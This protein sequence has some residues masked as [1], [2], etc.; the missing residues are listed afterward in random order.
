VS[1]E[2]PAAT[3]A[4]PEFVNQLKGALEVALVNDGLYADE[5][6]AMVDT[7]ER[8]YFLTP[9]VRMLYLLPQ[10]ETD[11]IIP[12]TISPVP[13]AVKR[14]M[15]IRLELMTPAHEKLLATWLTE[16]SQ[17][18]TAGAAREKFRSLGRFAEPHLSR[19]WTQSKVDAERNAASGLMKEI[20]SQ[21]KWTSTAVE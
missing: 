18:P 16:L 1:A 11:K 10:A 3:L 17:A 13:K 8:S 20:Q 2:I 12:L 5:A 14:T 21:R 9:G 7:W 6:R 4:H 19:A 15:V